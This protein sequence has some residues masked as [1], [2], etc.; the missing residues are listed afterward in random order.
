MGVR[1]LHLPEGDGDEVLAELSRLDIESDVKT[2]EDRDGAAAAIRRGRFDIFLLDARITS[3]TLDHL[4][5]Q[6]EQ[7]P[8]LAIVR[9]ASRE[10]TFDGSVPSS[11]RGRVRTVV[12][13]G[14]ERTLAIRV[15]HA[16]E[17]E[18]LRRRAATGERH[19]DVCRQLQ[20]RI[21]RTATR[22]QLEETL[23]E[24]VVEFDPY[25]FAWVGEHRVDEQLVVPR[26][27]A[28]GNGTYLSEV[29]I[30][31]DES[32]QGQGPTARAIRTGTLQVNQD[33]GANPTY[34][35]WREA[36][37]ERGFRSSA[38]IPLV[39][40]GDSYGVL[41]VYADEPNVFDA[42]EQQLLEELCEV[43]ACHCR[44]VEN[45]QRVGR[46]DREIFTRGPAVVVEWWAEEGWPVNV[47]SKNVEKVLGYTP[48]ELR[49]KSYAD[50]VHAED[51]ERLS[52]TVQEAREEGSETLETEYRVERKDGE[53]RWVKEATEILREN[54]EVR[55]Y[56]GYLVDVTERHESEKRLEQARAE[57]RQI[58]DMVPD[59]IFAKN[60]DGEYILANE[61]TAQYYGLTP[62]E[63]EGKTDHEVLPSAEQAE[64]YREDDRDII[65]SG[66]PRY[67]GEEE[68]TTADGETRVLQTTKIPYEVPGTGE[69]AVLGYGRDVTEL[70]RYE[71]KLERQRDNLEVLNQ[72]V[73]HD[74][75]NN[76]QII[77]SYADALTR[78]T[79]GT[80]Q[81]YAEK[82][83]DSSR[84][85]VHITESARE[86]AEA[87][88]QAESE[89]KSVNCRYVL[90]NELSEHRSTY[91]DALITTDGP[92]PD[93][94]VRADDM[95]ESVFRNLLTNAIE[96]NDKEMPEVTVS[97]TVGTDEVVIHIA[98][99]G[100]GIPDERK[101]EIFEE[102]KQGLDSGGTGLGLYLVTTLVDRY[103]GDVWVEDNEPEGAVFG[104]EL[105][106]A[107]SV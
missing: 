78:E 8:G 30:T 2:V 53:I 105:P 41:N 15:A 25:V 38:A 55:G 14:S 58:I 94:S 99:N 79:G 102:G 81:E 60:R 65:D 88:L 98:D 13:D 52:R 37:A 56:R 7:Y 18:Q 90:E 96:H 42:A 87:T 62:A 46:S 24:I 76:L 72:I 70:K 107:R 20:S 11:L 93:V 47:V 34:E 67:I 17:S 75:R 86:V 91:E 22:E 10:A 51:R 64:K 63:V 49:A 44:R 43:V 101:E 103:G 4:A 39:C 19:R 32:E 85:A 5:P 9:Y 26:V 45:W 28:G 1:V 84:S 61:T 16:V 57:L 59:L 106:L 73:R 92:I 54:G 29:A 97:A 6:L 21:A 23:C 82:I 80:Q 27:S 48:A 50:L 66:E 33:T 35:P 36:A 77:S 95:L 100:P 104:V 40:D 69:K 71:R 83:L 89:L 12:E 74:I 3:D 68:L 31:T